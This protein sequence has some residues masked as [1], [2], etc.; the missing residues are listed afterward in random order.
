VCRQIKF[1]VDIHQAYQQWGIKKEGDDPDLK[2]GALF[3]SKISALSGFKWKG[4]AEELY[5][6]YK[7]R[8]MPCMPCMPSMLSMLSTNQ[9]G[10]LHAELAGQE[11]GCY[12]GG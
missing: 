10:S 4:T 5:N 1:K 7:V 11:G 12:R 3:I 9:I 6:D 8:I 2:P